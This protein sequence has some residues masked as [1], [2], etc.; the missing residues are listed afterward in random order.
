MIIICVC[1]QT[2]YFTNW[3]LRYSSLCLISVAWSTELS[4]CQKEIDYL[5]LMREMNIMLELYTWYASLIQT[6]EWMFKDSPALHVECNP[7]D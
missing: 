5:D 4:C 3:F 1:V 7:G 6:L 2:R